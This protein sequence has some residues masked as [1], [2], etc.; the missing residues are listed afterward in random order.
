MDLD[1]QRLEAWLTLLEATSLDDEEFVAALTR[2]LLI[3]A[4]RLGLLRSP[5]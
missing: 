5:P 3:V 4:T 2:E 1:A